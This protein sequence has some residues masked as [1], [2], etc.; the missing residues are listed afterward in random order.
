MKIKGIL[1]RAGVGE[2]WFIQI[3][4]SMLCFILTRDAIVIFSVWLSFSIVLLFMDHGQRK[5]SRYYWS[6]SRKFFWAIKQPFPPSWI[7][8]KPHCLGNELD[9]HWLRKSPAVI[10][11]VSEGICALCIITS[12]WGSQIDRCLT[13]R[14]QEWILSPCS[15]L[16]QMLPLHHGLWFRWVFLYAGVS[17]SHRKFI[18]P[19]QMTECRKC[20]PFSMPYS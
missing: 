6:I 9:E 20:R 18:L 17:P 12:F 8:A 4:I 2:V 16:R 15:G 3:I 5:T 11:E 1:Q 10:L 19:K 14:L 13:K 7:A